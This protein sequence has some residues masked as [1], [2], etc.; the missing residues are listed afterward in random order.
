VT[1]IDGRWR[2]GFTSL[3]DNRGPGPLWIQGKRPPGSR[4]MNVTQLVTLAGGGVRKL[5]GAG[6]LHFTVAPPHYHWHLLG[7]DRYELRRAS[8]FAIVVRDRKSGF[9]LADHYGIAIGLP[10][11]PPRFLGNCEQFHPRAT[12]VQEGSSPGYTD[13]YP[14]NFHGQ[15]LDLTGVR[16]GN[17]WLVHRVNE[18]YNLRER[19]YDNDAASLLVRITWPGGRDSPP[20]VEPLR[21]CLA[22]RC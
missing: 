20:Q 7:F 12:F 11:G 14:A 18:L 13:R 17:Y 21:A 8:D 15:N 22:E 2:L 9:C 3:V 1:P 6:H 4:L 16:A 5:S 10:H 19:R